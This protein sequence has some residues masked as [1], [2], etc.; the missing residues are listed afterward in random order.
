MIRLTP[1]APAAGSVLQTTIT[2]SEIKPL[3]IKVLLPLMTH[4]SPSRTA[5]VRHALT[6]EP[7]PGSV[8]ATARMVSPAQTPGSQRCFCSSVPSRAM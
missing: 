5:V 1:L 8:I 7:P 6:S 3:E 4:S 2:M